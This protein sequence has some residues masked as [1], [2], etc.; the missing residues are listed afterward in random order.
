MSSFSLSEG[1]IAYSGQTLQ[2]DS[3]DIELVIDSTNYASSS[4]F[5][6]EW[7]KF[8]IDLMPSDMRARFKVAYVL[9]CNMTMQRFL[10]KLY[11]VCSGE[12]LNRPT[13][14]IYLN[15]RYRDLFG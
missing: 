12:L 2:R 10:R 5:P 14:E 15:V 8:F 11:N 6:I 1:Q 9:N 7:C 3:L 13:V 4:E